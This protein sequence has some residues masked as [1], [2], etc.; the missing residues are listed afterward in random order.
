MPVKA[1]REAMERHY[2][3][4]EWLSL[5]RDTFDQLHAYK[6]RQGLVTWEETIEQLLAGS[7]DDP[8]SQEDEAQRQE[9]VT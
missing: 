3:N 4:V 8:A 6:R 2:P 9:V 7:L 1:W 5:R